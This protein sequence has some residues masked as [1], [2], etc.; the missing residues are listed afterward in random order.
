MSLESEKEEKAVE[1]LMSAALR[2]FEK[3]ISDEAIQEFFDSDCTISVEGKAAL[4]RLC[5]DPLCNI[6]PH[7]N[8]QEPALEVMGDYA[9]MHRSLALN[10]VDEKTDEELERKRQEILKRIRERRRKTE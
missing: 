5:D 1:A 6:K 3:E 4:E 8:P 10:E 7:Q 2:P 9:A